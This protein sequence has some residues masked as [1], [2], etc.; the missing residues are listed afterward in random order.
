MA[1]IVQL[2]HQDECS[3]FD[4]KGLFYVVELLC[5]Y[6]SYQRQVNLNICYVVVGNACRQ[7]DYLIETA[8]PTALFFQF[9]CR[10][11]PCLFDFRS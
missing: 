9:F 10:N 2:D 5:K 4:V 6:L 11:V 3:D 8:P 7:G 1:S